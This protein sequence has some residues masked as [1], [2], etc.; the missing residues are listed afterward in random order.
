MTD[1]TR[2][3]IAYIVGRLTAKQDATAV[4]DYGGHGYSS[5][6][7]EV[8]AGRANV[9]DYERGCFVSGDNRNRGFSLFDYGTSGYVD[10]EMKGGSFE[11]FDYHSGS[12]FSG[13]VKRTDITIFDYEFGKYFSYSV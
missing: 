3:V 9:Y 11:G 5:F 13:E 4:F 2:R 12:Y 1:G 6:S 8:D 7:G 10:L